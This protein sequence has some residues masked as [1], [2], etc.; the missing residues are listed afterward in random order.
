MKELLLKYSHLLLMLLV[1]S[2]SPAIRITS[3]PAP[4]FNLS[5]YQTFAFMG[6]DASGEG[7][8]EG[9]QTHVSYLQDEI[10]RQLQG[11]GLQ[12]ATDGEA[13][14]LINLGIVVDE[15]MQ[16]RQTNI[17]TDPPRYVGQRRYTWQ[18]REVDVRRYNVGT[19]SVHLVDR[20]R[21]DMVW[22]GTAERI[23]SDNPKR[24]REQISKG[25][26]DLVGS[27]PG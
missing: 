7:L 15:E 25:M 9:Y 17:L 6:V 23:I 2:C 10:A 8:G 21:N 4:A 18:S 27:I 14:L 16:T 1:I 11:R 20:E 5:N 22:R 12:P 3:E 13:D 24:L 19:V 26:E